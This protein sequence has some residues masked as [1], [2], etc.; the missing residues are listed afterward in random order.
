MI[1]YSYFS[2]LLIYTID[3]G[4]CHGFPGPG[5]DHVYTFNPMREFVHG[6]S[7]HVDE[8]FGAFHKHHQK[9]YRNETE[10]QHRKNIF[11]QNMR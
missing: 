5:I 7:K 11:R 10:H 4:E 2:N 9:K 1:L 8:S 3:V 6:H